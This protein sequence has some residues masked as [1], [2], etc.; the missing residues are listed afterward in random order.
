MSPETIISYWKPEVAVRIVTDF[1]R[2]PL[3]YGKSA[4]ICLLEFVRARELVQLLRHYLYVHVCTLYVHCTTVDCKP[5]SLPQL[6]VPEAIQRNVV[7]SRSS[8]YGGRQQQQ[9]Y[10]KPPIHADEIGLTS[11]KYIPLNDTVSSLPLK[12]SYGP[13]SPQVTQ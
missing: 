3:H 8:S 13:M 2:Y 11:D 1:S 10:Y 12:I 4:Y 6:L 5:K 7:Q 9:L